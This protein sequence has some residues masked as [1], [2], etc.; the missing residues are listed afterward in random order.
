[1]PEGVS[2]SR[3]GSMIKIV[4]SSGAVPALALWL[5]SFLTIGIMSVFL[6]GGLFGR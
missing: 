5:G 3:E 1:M 4:K 6:M 2:V